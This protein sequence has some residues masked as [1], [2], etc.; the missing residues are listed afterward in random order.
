MNAS[1]INPR[2]TP[3]SEPPPSRMALRNRILFLVVAWVI[4]L[5]P[6]LFW[7]G[8][9]FGRP[10]SDQQIT[11]YLHDKSR[12]RH[13]QHALVQIGERISRHD[14]SVINWYP[15]LV[16]LASSPVEEIRNTDAWVMGQDPTQP[17]FHDALLTLLKD[18]S[19][20]VRGNAALALVRFG[21][22]SGHDQIVS[23]LA[24]A[25]ATAPCAGE[26]IDMSKPGTSLH[27]NGLVA[28][29]NTTAGVVEVRTPIGGRIR[30]MAAQ[31]G[32]KVST[33]AE[34]ATIDPPAD[35]IWEALRALHLIGRPED[36]GVVQSYESQSA[37]LPLR[38]SQ[39]ATLTEKAIRDRAAK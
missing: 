3:A 39:Q 6:F 29:L 27:H 38:I 31:A 17:E 11:E 33:G 15:D 30:S 7:R 9:W 21:D 34:L 2:Y 26:V 16:R 20:M 18:P 25:K 14:A 35:Q 24:P 4:V 37:H 5:M 28:K 22:A 32:S 13:T 36:L 10:L 23:L 8:T 19:A 1:A 12:P